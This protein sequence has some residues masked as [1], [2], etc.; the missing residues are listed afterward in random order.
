MSIWRPYNTKDTVNTVAFLLLPTQE[1]V[2][3]ALFIEKS[4]RNNTGTM[5]I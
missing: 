3:P 1:I 5:E 4:P 2:P